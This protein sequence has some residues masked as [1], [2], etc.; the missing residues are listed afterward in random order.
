MPEHSDPTKESTAQYDYPFTGW[1][2]ELK[3]VTEDATYKATF[4]TPIIRSYNVTWK[5]YGGST[6]ATDSYNYGVQP[7]YTGNTPTYSDGT[8]TLYTFRGWKHERTGEEY[9]AGATLPEVG[10]DEVFTAQYDII[11]ELVATE[12][13]PVTIDNNTKV[14]VTTVKVSGKLNVSAGTLTTTDLILEASTDGS[15]D[16]TGVNNITVP[17]AGHVYFDYTFDTDPWHWSS[18]GV[19]FEIDL[20]ANAPLKETKQALTL[21][22]DY[23]IVYYDSHERAT[24]GANK[25]CWKYVEKG[26]KKLTPGV[27]YLIAFNK[28]VG[29]VNVLR[30]TK[31]TGADIDY[32]GEVSMVKAGTGTN[33]NWNGIANPKTYHAILAAGTQE[34]QVHDGG[35]FGKDGYHTYTMKGDEKDYKFFVGKAAFVQVPEEQSSITVSAATDQDAIVKKAPRRAQATV[36]SDR[37]DIMIAPLDGEMA[38]RLF[39][40]A[41]E[42]KADEYVIVADLA[43][44]GVSPVRAQMWVNRYGEKL[45]KNTAPLVNSSADYPL[46]ISVPQTG[47]YEIYVNA[48]PAEESVLYLTF[49]GKPVWNLNYGGYITTLDKGTTERYGL[50]LVK[51]ASKIATGVEELTVENGENIRKV[52]VDDKIYII[53]NGKTFTVTGQTFKY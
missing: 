28:N 11:S 3:R 13:N 40:L 18:F 32:K 46:G 27:L 43:K 51:T 23:D 21:G 19:P 39:V 44:A 34:C 24:N 37:Y 47:E 1:D 5:N 33:A 30:F 26:N 6:I 2:P 10:G 7:S 53:R 15:G 14:D 52:L 31:A 25:N 50:R 29:H 42:D 48:Q 22:S 9:A 35:E 17:A 16:I 8:G 12:E 45:C 49:D 4:N 20:A 41:E 36:G 38:D